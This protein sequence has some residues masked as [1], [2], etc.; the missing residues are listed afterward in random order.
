MLDENLK[1][2]AL[3]EKILETEHLYL[4]ECV[5]SDVDDFMELDKDSEKIKFMPIPKEAVSR[6][7][8]LNNIKRLQDNYNNQI[9][10]GVWTAIEKR[11]NSFAG[12]FA[13]KHLGRSED[14]EIA[15]CI[16]ER[17]RGMGYATEMSGR[18]LEYASMELK[19]EKI[20]GLTNPE[21]TA[22]KKVLEKIGMSFNEK[23]LHNGIE[24]LFYSIDVKS[25][26]RLHYSPTA[27]ISRI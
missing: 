1:S 27:N 23:K 14:I 19:L 21:N 10:L 17:L 8:Q 24:M 13:L 9:G 6:E 25:Y 16:V 18:I 3:K 7:F 20:L 26:K 4:R 5:E 2:T 15:Y 22:S 11:N 12:W